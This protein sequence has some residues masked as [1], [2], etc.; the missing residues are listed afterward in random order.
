MLTLSELFTRVWARVISQSPSSFRHVFIGSSLSS[1]FSRA[2]YL[3]RAIVLRCPN[4]FSVFWHITR[5][6]L[7]KIWQIFDWLLLPKDIFHLACRHTIAL[8][9]LFTTQIA[10]KV[11]KQHTQNAYMGR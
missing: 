3:F 6:F 10:I 4:L 1:L 8:A 7:T 2:L 11:E 5:R 9:L